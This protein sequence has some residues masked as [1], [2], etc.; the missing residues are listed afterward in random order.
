MPL[1]IVRPRTGVRAR[2]LS[3]AGR[4]LDLDARKLQT[5]EV[6]KL[7]SE[8]PAQIAVRGWISSHKRVKDVSSRGELNVLGVRVLSMTANMAQKLSEEVPEIEVLPDR[9]IDPIVPDG[10]S[11]KEPE[12]DPYTRE[13]IHRCTDFVGGTGQG[14]VVAVLDTGVD[15]T[16]QEFAGGKIARGVEFDFISGAAIDQPTPSD[17]SAHGTHVAGLIC[18]KSVGLAPDCQVYSAVMLPNDRGNLSNYVIA[19]EWAASEPDI[20]IVNLS[21]GLPGHVPEMRDAVASLRACG[22]LTVAAIGN[23]GLHLTR[24]PGN[25]PEVLSVGSI[26]MSRNGGLRISPFTSRGYLLVDHHFYPVPACFAPGENVRSCVPGGYATWSGTSMAAP[27]ITAVAARLLG[28]SPLISL[29]DLYEEVLRVSRHAPHS[30]GGAIY[31]HPP[32]F[33]PWY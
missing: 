10:S 5:K 1:Y 26:G 23:D 33:Y 12:P 32:V 11:P 21:A 17:S 14:V 18:G 6:G 22:L 9:P 24:S 31:F 19:M 16:H 8:D 25:Y 27:L 29:V 30:D 20:Q 15:S 13:W 28:I 4:K 7:N 3:L 2:S